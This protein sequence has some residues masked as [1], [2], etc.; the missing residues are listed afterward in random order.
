VQVS[1]SFP[2]DNIVRVARDL[3]GAPATGEVIDN[4]PEMARQIGGNDGA[5]LARGACRQQGLIHLYRHWCD[6]RDSPD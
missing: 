4:N 1:Q 2:R 6:A 5:R 3:L